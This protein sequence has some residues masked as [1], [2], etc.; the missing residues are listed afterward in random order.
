MIQC[1]KCGGRNCVKSGFMQGMQRFKCK[2]CNQ[3]FVNKPR[4]GYGQMAI[5]T[6]VWLHLNGTS[7]RRIAKMF[8]VT[9][10]AVQKWIKEFKPPKE[11]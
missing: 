3:N 9:P 10:A 6:A 8:N 7:Q 5:A 2:D 4:R 11:P 1:F